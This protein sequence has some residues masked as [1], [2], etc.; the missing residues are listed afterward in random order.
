MPEISENSYSCSQWYNFILFV[1]NKIGCGMFFCR[2]CG[3]VKYYVHVGVGVSK[4]CN[5]GFAGGAQWLVFP[6]T[7]ANVKKLIAKMSSNNNL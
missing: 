4:L 2:Y 5:Y 1:N 7:I 3:V 6:K